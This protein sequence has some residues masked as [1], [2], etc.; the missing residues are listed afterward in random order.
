MPCVKVCIRC[1]KEGPHYKLKSRQSGVDTY[2]IVCRRAFSA[3]SDAKI[4]DYVLKKYGGKCQC[5]GETRREFL[6]IEHINGNGRQER[7]ALGNLGGTAYNC[8]LKR[9]PKRDDLTVLCWNCNCAKGKYGECPHVRE[10]RLQA[11]S[12]SLRLSQSKIH[13]VAFSATTA[14]ASLSLLLKS[15]RLVSLTV[16]APV[17]QQLKR[18]CPDVLEKLERVSE[19]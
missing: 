17:Y 3:A 19:P 13:C 12:V 18:E 16:P 4:R 1:G 10:R 15:G 8:Y 6:T 7:I 14:F 2:C 11:R 5:C 9:T